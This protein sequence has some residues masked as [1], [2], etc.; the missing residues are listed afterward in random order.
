VSDRRLRLAVAILT[1]AGAGIAGYLTYVHYAGTTLACPIG[2]GGC[3]TVQESRYAEL[4]GIPVALLGLAL[5]LAVL[6]LVVWDDERARVTVAAI[7]LA[8]A[9]F[10]AYLLA[11]QI[12]VI[13]AICAWCVANDAVIAL[14]AVAA[15]LRIPVRSWG[16]GEALSARSGRG[17]RPGSPR[18]P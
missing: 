16:P 10:A 6:G 12:F 13:D 17:S 11:I 4:V 1:L 15:V 2:G 3:E 14:L 5:Y 9:G 7:V 18:S 8:G